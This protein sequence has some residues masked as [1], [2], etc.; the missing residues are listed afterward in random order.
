M[1]LTEIDPLKYC[2]SRLAGPQ[3]MRCTEKVRYRSVVTDDPCDLRGTERARSTGKEIKKAMNRSV[4]LG[5]I[6]WSKPLIPI[7]LPPLQIRAS[8]PAV[9]YMSFSATPSR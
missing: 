5:V 6:G 1:S 2:R 9:S 3:S 7:D 8:S 4:V